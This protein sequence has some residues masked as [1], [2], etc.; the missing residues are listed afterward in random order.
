MHILCYIFVLCTLSL[1][2]K[3]AMDN[4]R[5]SIEACWH[6]NVIFWRITCIFKGIFYQLGMVLFYQYT[7]KSAVLLF[8]SK[9]DR[10]TC[11]IMHLATFDKTNFTTTESPPPLSHWLWTTR[12][13]RTRRGKRLC[14][15]QTR[16]A[17]TVAA[18]LLPLLWPGGNHNISFKIMSA[19]TNEK[20]IQ[21]VQKM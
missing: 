8:L 18:I 17:V 5:N 11:S 15:L 7:W 10:N 19:L 9:I 1:S 16:R 13:A 2:F 12:T 6:K 4:K 21:V 3:Q 20:Q 14:S